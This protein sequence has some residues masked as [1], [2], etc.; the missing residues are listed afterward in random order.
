MFSFCFAPSDVQKCVYNINRKKPPYQALSGPKDELQ[1]GLFW[2]AFI[3]ISGQPQKHPVVRDNRHQGFVLCLSQAGHSVFLLITSFNFRPFRDS[4]DNQYCDVSQVKRSFP[5]CRD[6]GSSRHRARGDVLSLMGEG[7]SRKNK[8]P[9]WGVYGVG[10]HKGGVPCNPGK[11][12][13]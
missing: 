3:H 5:Q 12:G 2:Y 4:K 9:S 10:D 7:R 13:T 8:E 6:C 1:D 11:Q